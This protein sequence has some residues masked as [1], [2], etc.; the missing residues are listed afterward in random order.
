MSIRQQKIVC[1]IFLLI[2]LMMSCSKSEKKIEESI[3]KGEAKKANGN[4]GLSA[5]GDVVGQITVGYQGWFSCAGDNSPMG[6]HWWHWTEA[7]QQTPTQGNFHIPS[8]PDNSEYKKNTIP[9]YRHWAMVRLHLC[10]LHL[11]IRQSMSNLN[12]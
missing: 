7:W 4:N 3:P 10:F 11:T 12:G 8:W 9:I 6:T 1:I 2:A 5:T